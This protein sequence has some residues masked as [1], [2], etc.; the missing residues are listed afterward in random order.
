MR[1]ATI[2]KYS[3]VYN[4]AIWRWVKYRTPF[5]MG[6]EIKNGQEGVRC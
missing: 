4:Y 2:V 1:I 5:I 6:I 3:V